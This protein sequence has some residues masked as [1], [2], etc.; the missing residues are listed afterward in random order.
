VTIRG[1]LVALGSVLE[2]WLPTEDG[3]V[4]VGVDGAPGT[5]PGGEPVC[6]VDWVGFVAVPGASA[7][8]VDWPDDSG[9]GAV[10]PVG[11]V[12]LVGPAFG[13]AFAVVVVAAAVVVVVVGSGVTSWGGTLGGP[14][15]PNAHPSTLPGGGV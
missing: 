10:E 11:A 14:P 5:E 15:E 8:P 13:L 12:G 2:E 9:V 4:V 3:P 6:E 1:S 7:A